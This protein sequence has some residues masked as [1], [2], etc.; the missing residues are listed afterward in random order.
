MNK[1]TKAFTLSE[2]TFW[3][4]VDYIQS[5]RVRTWSHLALKGFVSHCEPDKWTGITGHLFTRLQSKTKNK[6]KVKNKNTTT[7]KI[8]QMKH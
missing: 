2:A 1:I 8:L 3:L 6:T 7:E 5:L 4:L